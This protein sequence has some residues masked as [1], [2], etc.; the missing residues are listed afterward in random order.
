ML[1]FEAFIYLLCLFTSA[2]CTWLLVSAYFRRRQSLLLW[3]A[4]CFGL[5]AVNN[6]LVFVDLILLPQVDLSLARSLT[7]LLAGIV[8]LGSLIWGME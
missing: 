7:A 1:T 2:A 8:M 6:F 3:S 4:V 5:L